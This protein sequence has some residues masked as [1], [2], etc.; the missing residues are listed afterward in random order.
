MFLA[1]FLP[2]SRRELPIN[3]QTAEII[4]FSELFLP[5]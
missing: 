2:L 5:A 1:T 3:A 4:S